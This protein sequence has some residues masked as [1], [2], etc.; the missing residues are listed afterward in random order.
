M[1][2]RVIY[3]MEFRKAETSKDLCQG[4]TRKL[5]NLKKEIF[6]YRFMDKPNY[7][8]LK[9]MLRE[10]LFEAQEE[11]LNVNSEFKDL[12]YDDDYSEEI[13]HPKKQISSE[14]LGGIL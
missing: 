8:Y 3:A 10:L 7:E 9:D 6:K 4:N 12:D 14:S 13:I 11:S 1:E 2:E 5:Y